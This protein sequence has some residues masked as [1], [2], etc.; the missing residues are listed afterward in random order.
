M[1][2]RIQKKER[3]KDRKNERKTERKHRTDKKIENSLLFFPR[4]N[5]QRRNRQQRFQIGHV[6]RGLHDGALARQ[7]LQSQRL[8]Q[9]R[10]LNLSPGAKLIKSATE[11]EGR[12]ILCV[13][14]RH[15]HFLLDI[16]VKSTFFMYV[17]FIGTGFDSS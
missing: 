7:D 10:Q 1:G 14:R 11:C 5:S 4:Q 13:Y 6:G 8:G 16:L 9:Q 3:K 17:F 2:I 15:L 12:F